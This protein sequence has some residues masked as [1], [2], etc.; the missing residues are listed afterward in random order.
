M[1]KQDTRSTSQQKNTSH[2]LPRLH[3]LELIE[4]KYKL[5]AIKKD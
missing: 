4:S 2:N 3:M 5:H 1:K